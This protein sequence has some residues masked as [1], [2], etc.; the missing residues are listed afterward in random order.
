M[1]PTGA[2]IANIPEGFAKREAEVRKNL[3]MKKINEA[4]PEY[5]EKLLDDLIAKLEQSE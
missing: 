5:R 2:Y 3:I 4:P 1:V